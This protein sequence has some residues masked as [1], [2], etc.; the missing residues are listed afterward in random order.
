MLR[1]AH[2]HNAPQLAAFC[3]HYAARSPLVRGR[4]EFADLPGDVREQ[5][6]AAAV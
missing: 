1:V 4:P 5:V 3:R 2:N 6:M